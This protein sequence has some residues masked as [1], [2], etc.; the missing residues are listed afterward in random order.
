MFIRF[1]RFDLLKLFVTSCFYPVFSIK[2]I[3]HYIHTPCHFEH[4]H[5]HRHHHHPP[6]PPHHH[7]HHN[8]IPIM[9]MNVGML[10]TWECWDFGGRPEVLL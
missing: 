7:N 10:K 9:R 8:I 6:P 1:N 5:N 4:Y 2:V 3:S